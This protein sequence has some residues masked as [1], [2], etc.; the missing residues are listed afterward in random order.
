MLGLLAMFF[1]YALGRVAVRLHQ[2]G[3]PVAKALTWI[4]RISVAVIAILW[5]GGLDTLGIVLLCLTALSVAAGVYL[6]MRP[7]RTEEIH[8]FP[9]R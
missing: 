7:K 8:L 5:T 6:E 9:G 1:G 4:L 2:S 3:Q